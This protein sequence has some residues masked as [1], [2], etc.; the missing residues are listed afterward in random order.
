MSVF[1]DIKEIE[2]PQHGFQYAGYEGMVISPSGL[3]NLYDNP[4][5]WKKNVILKEKTFLGNENTVFGSCVHQ[6]AEEYYA[7]RLNKDMS[8]PKNVIEA[9]LRSN[10]NFPISEIDLDYL[11]LVCS[12]FRQEYLELNPT[13]D[14]IEGYVEY[15]ISNDIKIAGSYDGLV[16]NKDG[17][18]TVVDYKTSNKSVSDIN[19]YALQMSVYATLL[20]INR[21]IIISTIRAVVIVKNK[22]PKVI[23]LEAKPNIKFANRSISLAIKKIEIATQHPEIIDML[24]TENP[25]SFTCESKIIEETT[26]LDNNALTL[27]RVKKDI[28]G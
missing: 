4:M 12:V 15:D 17:T 27:S 11:Q 7:G 19:Q 23:V 25:F 13:P 6:Y 14:E 18:Y 9:V 28:F 21:N 22:A 8:M 16:K 24:F 10:N 20:Q 3:R 2:V 1:D 5:M 26:V